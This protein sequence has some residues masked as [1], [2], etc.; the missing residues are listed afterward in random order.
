MPS[1][2]SR[3]KGS[4]TEQAYQFLRSLIL[5]QKLDVGAVFTERRL[6]EQINASR[7]PLRT[8]INRLEGEGLIERLSNGSIVIR[9][10]AVEELLEILLVRRLLEGE[11]AAQCAQ[12]VPQEKIAEM[13][14]QS[15]ELLANPDIEFDPFWSYDDRFHLFIAEGSGK[16]MLAKMIENLRDKVRMCHMM[17][18]KRNFAEQAH[19][20]IEVLKALEARDSERAREAMAQHLDRVRERLMTWLMS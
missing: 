9:Q 13:M 20:H 8:A 15:Q 18:M 5:A 7:T 6:A 1:A 10:V 2:A 12:R 14:A 19:E 3:E 16:P 17:R 4:I 11:A